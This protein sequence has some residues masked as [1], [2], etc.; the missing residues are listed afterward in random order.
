MTNE[1]YAN[2]LAK[3]LS[4]VH[5]K[6][7]AQ[8]KEV[9]RWLR[10]KKPPPAAIPRLLAPS[11][12]RA[13]MDP[14]DPYVEVVGASPIALAAIESMLQSTWLYR[15]KVGLLEDRSRLAQTLLGERAR[16]LFLWDE[17]PGLDSFAAKPPPNPK[18]SPRPT[19][20]D[21]RLFIGDDACQQAQELNE[22]LGYQQ[23]QR[24]TRT[25]L[26][27]FDRPPRHP[28]AHLVTTPDASGGQITAA[29]RGILGS[30]FMGPTICFSIQNA[31]DHLRPGYRSLFVSA[32]AKG[33]GSLYR[34]P[35]AALQALRHYPLPIASKPCFWS[36]RS[37][38]PIPSPPDSS[39]KP[40]PFQWKR[41]G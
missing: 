37:T 40:W 12:K 34:A 18:P 23:G 28:G 4:V 27:G 3:V 32:L 19:V 22:R 20:P 39:W 6:A 2:Q 29:L 25:V 8:K 15:V 14:E 5:I 26:L 13:P 24:E 36:W 33:P 38:F 35:H 41:S 30:L 11:A 1:A 9:M 10:A 21:I 16:V 17:L 31:L 7:L